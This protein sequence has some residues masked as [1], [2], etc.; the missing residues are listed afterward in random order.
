MRIK[1]LGIVF[2]VLLSSIS[3][4]QVNAEIF[5]SYNL[6]EVSGKVINNKDQSPIYAAQ[7]YIK[8]NS[9]G[10]IT[11]EQGRF[12]LKIPANL[13][14]DKLV[15]SCIGYY[16]QEIPLS[17]FFKQEVT[18]KLE[19]QTYELKE[20]MVTASVNKAHKLLE[21]VLRK[22]KRNY[23]KK[24]VIAE[25]FYREIT[26]QDDR[27]VEISEGIIDVYKASYKKEYAQDQVKI[28]KGRTNF[29]YLN[30]E[31]VQLD[32]TGGPF[33]ALDYDIVKTIPDFM[34]RYY[35][36][37]YYSYAITSEIELNGRK[38]IVLSFKAKDDIP[39][40]E[41]EKNRIFG[42]GSSTK[43]NFE[44]KNTNYYPMYQGKLY[45][46]SRSKAIV[47]AEYGLTPKG[48]IFANKIW[49]I[50][51]P[52]DFYA[53][54]NNLRITIDYRYGKKYWM[55]SNS[56]ID[57]KAS[58]SS[59]DDVSEY[60]FNFEFDSKAELVITKHSMRKPRK[61]RNSET[62][63]VNDIFASQISD[64]NEK[65]WDTYNYISP[66]Q[67]VK[68]AFDE[69]KT[70][71]T[72]ADEISAIIENVY[73]NY[74]KEK[75]YIQTDKEVYRP[76]E[77]LLFKT[78]VRDVERNSFSG[79]S[80]F[81]TLLLLDEDYKIVE[82]KKYALTNGTF[83][84]RY[85]LPASL[86]LGTF[87]VIAYTDWMENYGFEDIFSKEIVIQKNASESIVT[88]TVLK[89]SVYLSNSRLDA[90]V[91]FHLKKFTLSKQ[92][93]KYAILEDDK[94]IY[95]ESL[96]TNND[97]IG[98]IGYAF[99]TMDSKKDY[100]LKIE[101]EYMGKKETERFRIPTQKQKVNINFF[102]EGG[103]FLNGNVCKVA[104][105]VGSSSGE[106]VSVS[107]IVKNKNGEV[108]RRTKTIHNG[109]GYFFIKAEEGLSFEVTDLDVIDGSFPLPVPEKEGFV[110]NLISNTRDY[111]LLKVVKNDPSLEN[112]IYATLKCG[113]K[114]YWAGT[115]KISDFNLF[116][117]PL[118]DVPQGI[119]EITLF[120]SLKIPKAERLVYV[121]SYKKLNILAEIENNEIKPDS[122]IKLSIDTYNENGI[123]GPSELCVSVIDSLKSTSFSEEDIVSYFLLKS[124]IKGHLTNPAYYLKD[125]EESVKALDLLML[126]QG[127]RSYK[128]KEI[129]ELS[130]K[131]GS[132]KN[133]PLFSGKVT[134]KEG[135]L[136]PFAKVTLLNTDLFK[137][138]EANCDEKGVFSVPA[139]VFYEVNGPNIIISAVDKDNNKNVNIELSE[140]YADKFKKLL[141]GDVGFEVSES[142]IVI[143]KDDNVLTDREAAK[144]NAIKKPVGN[145]QSGFLLGE[146]IV[147]AR[148]LRK[149]VNPVDHLPRVNTH[150]T[151]LTY[152][153]M[154]GKEIFTPSVHPGGSGFAYKSV[155]DMVRSIHPCQLWTNADDQMREAVTDAKIVFR[156]RSSKYMVA[157]ALFV[158]DG[159]PQGTN[160][161]ELPFMDY[162]SIESIRV[163]PSSLAGMSYPGTTAG[164]VIEITTK[165][166]MSEE[167]Y[168]KK[169]PNLMVLR[170]FKLEK[171][172]YPEDKKNADRVNDFNTTVFWHPKV[173]T[174]R[175][176]KA[177]V[178]FK[179]NK[180]NST[181]YIKIEGFNNEGNIGST[182]LK[183]KTKKDPTIR[184]QETAEK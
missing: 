137:R 25:G 20:V 166:V 12:T 131:T 130:S 22:I 60:D 26:N 114:I 27:H 118:R 37:K 24:P 69:L 93:F 1:L 46:D 126:T 21:K 73:Q 101:T 8:D 165:T 120:D 98:K 140:G 116:K 87:K 85:I 76:G 89:D 83:S 174:N 72:F 10:N 113:S 48:V 6:N 134:Y 55:L 3:Y 127:W 18:I 177:K 169:D 63:Q 125:N 162:G 136:V 57:L 52:D 111:I 107:G 91:K 61:F 19:P 56:I 28:I 71:D 121:N 2:S 90:E 92:K 77:E 123:E 164:G 86:S 39:F 68:A 144:I 117:I 155:F 170:K 119:C 151:S 4:G 5:K 171:E 172:Y 160:I 30:S 158:I 75:I 67:S 175:Q 31:I 38:T 7:V 84:G 78:Y 33:Y 133:A 143:K 138:I 36:K 182:I 43:L 41:L 168:N 17:E 184:I 66:K 176:G 96:K 11:N 79:Y 150:L 42:T 47:R 157:G 81:L 159:I 54:L 102:P 32:L 178:K 80:D 9:I 23:N 103:V 163:Y 145:M 110:M 64:F 65:F 183:Y 105:K 146:A 124:K 44:E 115:S 74:P 141:S 58:V 49:G 173:L 53:V 62:C 180:L 132:W 152:K 128:W 108:L 129:N 15:V 139:G 50:E 142:S 13:K 104:F 153:E 59:K 112:R 100:F 95:S 149:K 29:N 70:D 51:V 156:G 40:P 147:K 148:K 135:G 109:M 179:Q 35:Y 97:G 154:K 181:F 161:C 99:E 14:N 122:E 45:I 94:Q 34:D 16:P 106:P 88:E 82:E 167:E